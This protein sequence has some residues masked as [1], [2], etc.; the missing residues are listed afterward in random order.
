MFVMIIYLLSQPSLAID[1]EKCKG[2]HGAIKPIPKYNLTKNCS[3]CHGMHATDEEPKIRNPEYVHAIHKDAGKTVRQ[4]ACLICHQSPLECTKCHNSHD[5]LIDSIKRVIAGNIVNK[6]QNVSIKIPSCIDCHG[7][8][9]QPK[10]H[11]DFRNALLS[12]KHK[13]MTCD[14]CHLNPYTIED[15]Y[16]FELRFKNLLVA[17]IDDSIKICRICHSSIYDKLIDGTHGAEN[18][19]CIN[20]HNPHTTQLT[21]PKF[22]MV[23]PTETP[24][25][26]SV[27]VTKSKDWLFEKIPILNNPTLI[28]IILILIFVF[29]SEYILSRHEEGQKVAYNMVKFKAGE[30]TLK[31]LEVK[32]KNQDIN[33]VN[34]ILKE[35]GNILGMT[36]STEEDKEDPSSN[37]YKYVIFIDVNKPM[38]EIEE[39]DLMNKI[40]SLNDIRSAELTDK[41][42]L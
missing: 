40:S 1:T 23:K 29:S 20:C 8:L 2:C 38:D 27:K 12:S 24:A 34:Q 14:T 33:F 18:K 41:Y 13:W 32:I 26:I 16:K 37:I 11:E 30:E 39:S 3:A 4:S 5:N 10:G 28:M 35:H 25:N 17:S 9:P 42:E 7:N 15:D 19:T 21:G 6:S 31:I 22:Q 36:M